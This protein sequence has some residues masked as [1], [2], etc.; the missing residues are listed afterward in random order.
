MR[1][2]AGLA[3][4]AVGCAVMAAGAMAAPPNLG[5]CTSMQARCAVEIGGRCNPRTGY[6]QYGYV[7]GYATGTTP[8]AYDAC[9]SRALANNKRK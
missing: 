8:E 4:A 9:I 1:I 7:R 5:K 6:W 2:G 3:V